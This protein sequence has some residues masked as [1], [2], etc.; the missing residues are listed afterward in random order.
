MQ[1]QNR[2]EMYAV[3]VCKINLYDII[4][5]EIYDFSLLTDNEPKGT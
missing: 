5:K 3:R 4:F 2:S 1:F